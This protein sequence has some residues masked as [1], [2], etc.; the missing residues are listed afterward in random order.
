MFVFRFLRRQMFRFEVVV[1]FQDGLGGNGVGFGAAAAGDVQSQSFA[2]QSA[3]RAAAFIGGEH[4]IVLD[5][6]M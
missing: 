2:G 1:D 4:G 5:D 3:N 6:G